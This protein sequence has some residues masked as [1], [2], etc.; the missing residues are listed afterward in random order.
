[1]LHSNILSAW[2]SVLD[3]V[4]YSVHGSQCWRMLETQC[5]CLSVDV[6]YSVHWSQCWRV[7]HT[8]NGPCHRVY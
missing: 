2:V 4:T 8:Q 3:S 5:M 7:L 1:M 6:T